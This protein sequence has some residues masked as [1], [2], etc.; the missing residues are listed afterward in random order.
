MQKE[1][2]SFINKFDSVVHPLTKAS[3]LAYWNAS[4][5]GNDEDWEKSEQLN[6][7]LTKV[8][9]NKEDFA[10][11]KRIKESNTITDDLLNRQLEVLFN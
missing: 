4:I 11:L 1:F 8:F 5:S 9:A 2:L 7:E 3:A 10:I 6:I